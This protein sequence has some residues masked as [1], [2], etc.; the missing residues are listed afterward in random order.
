MPEEKIQ[1]VKIENG[2]ELGFEFAIGVT[3]FIMLLLSLASFVIW[4]AV[5]IS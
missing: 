3:F 1:K 4:I 2:F 5:R